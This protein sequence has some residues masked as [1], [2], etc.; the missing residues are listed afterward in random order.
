M[1]MLIQCRDSQHLTVG[2]KELLVTFAPGPGGFG[3]AEVAK[4]DPHYAEKI[5]GVELAATSYGIV[6]LGEDSDASTTD[7]GLYCE[8]CRR[9][10]ANEVG[11]QSHMRKHAR[12][13]L[14][15]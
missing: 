9:A 6:F 13:A 10:F 3:Y 14:G 4:D 7:T 8:P 1:T 5:H 2:D 12:E 11:L 15:T